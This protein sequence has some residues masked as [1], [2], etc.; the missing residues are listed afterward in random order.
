ME[1]LYLKAKEI[2]KKYNQEQLLLNYENFNQEQKK[3][4]LNQILGID[5][6]LINKLYKQTKEKQKEEKCKIEP[7]SY[8]DKNELTDEQ[9]E[10]YMRIR[11]KRNKRR[12]ISSSNNGWRTRN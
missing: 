10:Y 7:I 9:K 5:F 2:L 8:I 4:L 11:N 3:Y 6:E 12:K 1:E